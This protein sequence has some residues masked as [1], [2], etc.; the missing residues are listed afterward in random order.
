MYGSLFFARAAAL[1]Q[2]PTCSS[3]DV[4]SRSERLIDRFRAMDK[5]GDGAVDVRE[6]IL[7][8]RK[9][10]SRR[11]SNFTG[12]PETV[13]QEDGTREAFERVFQDM[14]ANGDRM[15]TWPEFAAYCARRRRAS[16]AAR[17]AGRKTKPTVNRLQRLKTRMQRST[18]KKRR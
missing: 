9:D 11:I 5:N 13:R 17:R 8:L 14:D 3:V 6:F 15:V 16:A 12:V 2:C 1:V 18:E 7:A 10:R 4:L